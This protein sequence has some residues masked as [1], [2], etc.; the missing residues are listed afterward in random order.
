MISGEYGIIEDKVDYEER[1]INIELCVV[2]AEDTDKN[3]EKFLE[4]L[5]ELL[6]KYAI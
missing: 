4:E 1:T 2:T 3:S 6:N 5:Q